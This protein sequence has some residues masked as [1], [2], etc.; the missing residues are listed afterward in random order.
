MAE[1]DLLNLEETKINSSLE[2]KILMV[3]STNNCGKSKVASQLYP[4]QTLFVATEKGYNA[5]GGA[6]VIDT[7]DWNTFRQVVKQ[8]TNKKTFKKMHETYKAIVLPVTLNMRGATLQQVGQGCAL[9]VLKRKRSREPEKETT[10][11][12]TMVN[13]GG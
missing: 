2:S 3:Y 13:S 11:L 10:K 5:L 1:F 6:R 8:L 9:R 4:H 7:L 12:L